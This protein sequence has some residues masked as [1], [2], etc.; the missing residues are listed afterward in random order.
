MSAS[1]WRASDAEFAI[2]SAARPA[3]FRLFGLALVA[4]DAVGIE[5]RILLHR[6]QA[7]IIDVERRIGKHIVERFYAGKWILE[8]GVRLF[9]FTGDAIHKAVHLRQ[10]HGLHRLLHAAHIDALRAGVCRAMCMD[11]TIDLDEHAAGAASR[12]EY[13]PFVRLD[14]LDHQLDHGRRREELTALLAFSARKFA[15]EILV[16]LAEHIA[17]GVQWD[18]GEDAQ[19]VYQNV[20]AVALK[21]IVFVL[22]Q[23]AAQ[24]ILVLLNGLHRSLD[25]RDDVGLIGQVEQLFVTRFIRQV[26]AAAGD[27]NLSFR[28]LVALALHA[29]IFVVDLGLVP[30]IGVVGKLQEDQAEHRRGVFAGFQVGV[31]A[32]VIGGAP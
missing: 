1:E 31:C 17:G 29:V 25:R 28:A 10:P 23:N 7:D 8:V 30:A 11:V 24:F 18:V 22:R 4:R 2:T 19:Q 9:D 20:R 5:A 15:E 32:Q 26:E 12:I 14:D 6:V 3:G 27:G 16:N 13:A 21:T